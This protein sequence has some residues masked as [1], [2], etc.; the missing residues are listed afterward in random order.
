MSFVDD[1]MDQ[2]GK[3]FKE[4]RDL[5]G[6]LAAAIARAEK[7][8]THIASLGEV[9]TEYAVNDLELGTVPMPELLARFSAAKR[10]LPLLSRQIHAGPWRPA[11]DATQDV[12]SATET[13]EGAP[14]G[15]VPHSPSSSGLSEPQEANGCTCAWCVGCSCGSPD[16]PACHK[17]NGATR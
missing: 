17:P 5:S 12:T 3:L 4:N 16:C 9:G 13:A 2:V 10:D 7:A 15:A 14:S 6:Q 1:V 11:A 8:E